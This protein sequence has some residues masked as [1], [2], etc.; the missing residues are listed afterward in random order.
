MAMLITLSSFAFSQDDSADDKGKI[1]D[2]KWAK[3][4][5]DAQEDFLKD[6]K[7]E[8][9]A[10]E[11]IDS[12]K[13]P[14]K[15]LKEIDKAYKAYDKS[16]T[17]QRYEKFEDEWEDF[18][19]AK[20][21]ADKKFKKARKTLFKGKSK[22]KALKQLQQDLQNIHDDIELSIKAHHKELLSNQSNIK[23]ILHLATKINSK[24]EDLSKEM[25]SGGSEKNAYDFAREYNKIIEGPFTV[26]C[27]LLQEM[28][29]EYDDLDDV[30]T[31]HHFNERPQAW[32]V[33]PNTAQDYR[34]IGSIA[35][36]E[37]L[38][39]IIAWCDDNK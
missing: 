1:D 8:K 26:M 17:L 3:E 39:E 27:A 36:Q 9:D 34:S 31:A 12:L 19:K 7:K 32:T 20:K 24:V 16:E 10:Q 33:R 6:R 37:G 29:W 28:M 13:I 11:F 2:G 5:K 15:M 25:Y 38:Q 18:L 21:K 22:K 23:K 30:V 35:L 4:W 14:N